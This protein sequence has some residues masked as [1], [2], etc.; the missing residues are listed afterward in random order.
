MSS[1]RGL[2]AVLVSPGVSARM[3]AQPRHD[4]KPEVQ[5]RRALYHSGMRFRLHMRP[6]PGLRRE[7]DLVFLGARVA[8][9]VDG[10]FWHGCPDHATWPKANADFWRT[11]IS[12]NR[13]RDRDT[14][15]R[16]AGAGWT[17]V[18]VWEHEDILTAAD[19]VRSA[20]LNRRQKT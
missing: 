20:V 8:V 18:R 4:T 1:R 6:I 13:D 15:G 11:K 19:R 7:A 10:C 14:V 12:A 2:P 17:S 9:F 5:L 16:L 3:R